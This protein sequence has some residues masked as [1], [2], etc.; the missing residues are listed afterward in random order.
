MTEWQ[1]DRLLGQ[2]PC[3]CGRVDT[4]H[5]ECYAGK[6]EKQV[7]AAYRKVYEKIRRKLA[8]GRIGTVLGVL[9]RAS[10]RKA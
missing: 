6:T 5:Q 7:E 3:L 9:R 2:T 8:Q 10:T 1:I 4:W